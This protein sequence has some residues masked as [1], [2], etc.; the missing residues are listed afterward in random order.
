MVCTIKDVANRAKVSVGTVSN[1]LSGLVPVRP[2]LRDRVLAVIQELDYHPNSVARSLKTKQTKMLGMVISDITN[3]FFPQIA[4]GAENAALEHGYL[5][6]VFNTDDSVE[7]EK[8]VLSVMRARRMDGILL[9]VAP[10]AGD[11]SHIEGAIASGVPIVCLDRTPRGIPVDLVS[12]DNVKGAA[13]CVRHLIQAGHS[14]IGIITG[15]MELQ[16]G[17]DRLRGYELAHQEEKL[18]I[19]R[20]LIKEGDFRSDSGY[21]LGKELLFGRQRPTALFACNGLMGLGVVK[22]LNELRLECPR[23]VALAVFDD[24]PAAELFR[25]HLTAVCQPSYQIGYEGAKLIIQRIEGKLPKK[26]VRLLLE[27]E[28]KTRESTL[29]YKHENLIL[30]AEKA[31]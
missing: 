13:M 28:L 30:T 31:V 12:I 23:D 15:S 19:D 27:P 5:L 8:Q 11:F 24:I 14:R 10:N 1:V 3:P 4:R 16:T 29:G 20:S 21:R 7:R 18:L 17:R 25:P 9:V 26:R 2:K 22:A 6:V